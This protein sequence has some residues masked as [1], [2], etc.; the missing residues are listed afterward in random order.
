MPWYKTGTVKATNN[1]NAIIGA[2]TAFIANSRVGDAFR[3]PDGAWYEVTNIA[4]DTAMSISPNYQGATIAAGSY[5]L[6]PMQGYVKDLADQARTIINQWGATLA[7]LGSVSTENIV[8]VAKGGTGGTTP[9]AAR[10]GLGLGAAAVASIVGVVSQSG[11]VATGAIVERGGNENGEYT[12]FADGTLICR[13]PAKQ[14]TY[15]TIN[16]LRYLW[17]FPTP[18]AAGTTP[19]ISLTIH[20]II[21]INKQ[22]SGAVPAYSSAASATCDIYSKGQFVAGDEVNAQ[23]SALSIGR[24]F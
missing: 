10:A 1:S 14:T 11:G 13:I 8:P 2:G 9:A 3:G 6:A 22:I 12:K 16:V 19:M 7:G 4:S 21:G 20:G 24:W 23:L 15:T 18:F 5:A 17:T